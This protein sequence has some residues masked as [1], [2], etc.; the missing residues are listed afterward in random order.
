MVSVVDAL[1]LM[2]SFRMFIVTLLGL[3]I[4]IVKL[5][6][7]NNHHNFGR[8]MVI[9][10]NFKTEPPSFNGFIRATCRDMLPFCVSRI[11]SLH[12][13]YYLL[14]LYFNIFFLYV[15]DLKMS[16][17]NNRTNFISYLEAQK[18]KYI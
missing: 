17:N 15:V 7:K 18:S 14:H 1:N 16:T 5:N 12:L 13:C 6:H 2:F 3:V 11:K 10:N 8:L 9:F 4:A